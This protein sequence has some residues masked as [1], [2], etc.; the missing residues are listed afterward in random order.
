MSS[1]SYIAPPFS[2]RAIRGAAE[3]V[4]GWAPDPSKPY[5]DITSFLELQL[6][7]HDPEFALIVSTRREMG[8]D[9]ARAYIADRTIE[10]RSDVYDHAH[11]GQPFARF[12]LAHELGHLV[13]H[14]DIRLARRDA[15]YAVDRFRD[16]EWQ[17]DCF[18]GELLMPLFIYQ[19]MKNPED[20]ANAFGVS[21]SA[22]KAQLRAWRR[23]R[24][25]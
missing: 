23:E 22:V 19:E 3:L 16:P 18:A 1:H 7:S 21:S 24:L 8:N 13:L 10:V 9:L 17:A 12:T 11:D 15:P 6:Q 5:F 4:R 2:R 20:A 14:S 25:I